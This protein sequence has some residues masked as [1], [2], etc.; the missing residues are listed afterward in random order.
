[1]H[2]RSKRDWS[3]DV[4]SSDL[5]FNGA[6]EVKAVNVPDG[7]AV[8]GIREHNVTL[9]ISAPENTFPKLTIADFAAELDLSGVRQPSSD[10]RVIGRVVSRRDVQIIEVTPPVV[11]VILEPVS[12]RTVPVQASLQGTTPQ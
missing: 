10:Q 4:C 5:F 2:T 1:R 6:I 8:A 9:K 11:T 12:T 7:L 3:S